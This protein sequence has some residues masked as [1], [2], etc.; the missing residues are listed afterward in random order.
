ML[1]NVIA[2]AKLSKISKNSKYRHKKLL[3]VSIFIDLTYLFNLI[4]PNIHNHSAYLY[5]KGAYKQLSHYNDSA[6][7]LFICAKL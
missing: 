4:S 1:N 3:S 5:T 6:I 2:T 7:Q